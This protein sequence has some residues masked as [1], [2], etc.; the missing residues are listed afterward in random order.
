MQAWESDQQLQS[1]PGYDWPDVLF[2][3]ESWEL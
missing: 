2:E 1:T 3:I